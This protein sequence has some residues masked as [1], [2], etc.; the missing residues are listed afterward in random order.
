LV[1]PGDNIAK[2]IVD[3]VLKNG[4]EIKDGD[5]LVVAHKI[6]SKIENRIVKIENVQPSERAKIFSKKTGKSPKFVEIILRETKRIIKANKE[7]FLVE[8]NRG[9]ICINAG[10]DKSNIEGVNNYILLPENPDKSAEKLRFQIKEIT[11]RTIGVIIC[12]TYSRP[13]RRG[14]VNFAIGFSGLNAFRDYRGKKDLFE[15]TLRVKN[16]AII[17]EIS[18]ASELLMGQ[19]K[20][21]TPVVLLRGL[22][23]ILENT[24]KANISDI[25]ISGKEDLFRNIL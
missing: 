18:A 16:V 12:D 15:H 2:I 24:K 8:D 23:Q 11:G 10:I 22:K 21:G 25:L 7:I 17:D 19:G 5:I 3:V 20:E 6:F 13:F 9:L 4:L 1:N 14:Q